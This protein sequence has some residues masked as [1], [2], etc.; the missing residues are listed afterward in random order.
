M[1]TTTIRDSFQPKLSAEDIETVERRLNLVF[2]TDY[3]EFL[4][5]HN[6]GRPKPNRF[7]IRGNRSDTQGIL[8]WLYGIH[9]DGTYNL[10]DQAAMFQDRVPPE[11]L[12]IGEDPGGNLI[13][14]TISGSNRNH[15]YFWTH[16]DE[17]DEGE[18]PSYDNIYFVADSFTELLEGLTE[19]PET[20]ENSSHP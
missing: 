15:V 11:L 2:P 8:S 12:P 4:L 19:A 13:C 10:I 9:D 16:E 1:T 20:K 3:K 17:V 7:P 6:G 18:I 5:A 14:L